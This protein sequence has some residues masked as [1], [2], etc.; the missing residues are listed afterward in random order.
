MAFGFGWSGA[1]VVGSRSLS[2][3]VWG[4]FSCTSIVI[5]SSISLAD[6]L[7]GVMVVCLLACYLRQGDGGTK[8]CTFSFQN[9]LF[10]VVS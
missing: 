6:A 3:L 9:L 1:G 7:T 10:E 4:L 5:S 2:I 8:N